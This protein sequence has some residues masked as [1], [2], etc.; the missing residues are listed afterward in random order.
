[1][2]QRANYFK[3]GLFVIGAIAAGI[4]V[5]LIIGTGRFLQKRV[6]IETYFN[7]SVQGLD[8]GSKMKYRGV[9]VGQ[10]TRISFTYVKYEQD[11]PMGDRKRYVLV[12]AQMQPR[13]VGGK[14]ANDIASPEST[15][16]EVEKGL[17]VKLAPQGITGTSY[18]EIDYVDA[19]NNPP[20]PI[21]WVPDS[22]YIPSAPSTVGQIVNSA[23]EILERIHNLDVETVVNNLNKLL[24]TTNDRV[25]ALD[26]KSLQ[27]RTERT[28]AKI[29]STLNDIAAKK[30]SDEAL[31]LLAELRKSNAEL[32]ATLTNP[33]FKKLPESA[34]AAIQKVRELVADPKLASS[35]AHMERT[36]SRLDRIF[37]GAESDLT[38]T[39]ENLRQI[40]DNLRDLT[41]DAKRYPSNVI[42]GAPPRPLERTP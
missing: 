1:M 20:L 7:E 40:S 32:Q 4:I 10:V 31:A 14:A 8:I 42:F 39:I 5:L 23:S 3:L 2:S 26:T 13:L 6:T 25:A 35:I 21:D 29:E 16:L 18:L 9:E 34:D 19:A 33:T 22:I 28:L 12:E 27:Q 11:K 37:G 15:A 38:T 24:T 36:L 17:R 41:E 30:L